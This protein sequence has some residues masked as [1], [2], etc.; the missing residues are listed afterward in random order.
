MSFGQPF[1]WLRQPPA[2]MAGVR[3]VRPATGP[4]AWQVRAAAGFAVPRDALR[5]A[6][7]LLTLVSIGRIHQQFPTLALLRP[8]LILVIA[9]G[10]YALLNPRLVSTANLKRTWPPRLVAG[11]GILACCSALFGIS[12]GAS[13]TFIL[14]TY[15]KVLV[16]AFLVMAATRSARDLWFF[17]WA[18][19]ASTGVLVWMALFVFKLSIEPGDATERLGRLHMYDGN[20]AAVVLLIGLPLTLLAFQVSKAKGK[21]FS[22]LIF[23]GIGAALARTG[24]RSGFLGAVAVG[25]M[26]LFGVHSISFT[27]RLVFAVLA[28]VPLILT[29][30]SGY[31][32]RIST[33]A[34][35]TE[36]YNWEQMDGRIQVWQ[37]GMGYMVDYPLFGIGINNFS[38]AEGTIS[39]KARNAPRGRGIRW[40]APHNSFVEAGAELGVPGLILFSSLVFGGIWAM[41][42][43]QRRLPRSWA[44]G[45]LEERFLYLGSG[46]FATSMVGFAVAASFVSHA[47]LDHFYYLVALMTGL[48]GCIYDRQARFAVPSTAPPVPAGSGLPMLGFPAPSSPVSWP[49]RDAT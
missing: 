16:F 44:S 34:H 25:L 6:L 21:V 38:R 23:V 1:D 43:L 49:R 10:V 19:V 39:E 22:A 26:L 42:R 31:W 18:Y 7:F 9:T 46:Y 48:Y 20:D 37:R 12:L 14:D 33:I 4:K 30:P 8:A 36:D 13:A 28:A 11:L 15:S 29:A 41:V 17:V 27:R 2:P 47:Y 45:T 24:S 40:T 35:P 32:E 5:L 3:G